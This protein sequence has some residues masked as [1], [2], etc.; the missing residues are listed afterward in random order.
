MGS[1]SLCSASSTA[2]QRANSRFSVVGYSA[3]TYTVATFERT[4]MLEPSTAT[5]TGDVGG[6]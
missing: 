5:A 4:V 6:Y 2:V 1:D 3:G